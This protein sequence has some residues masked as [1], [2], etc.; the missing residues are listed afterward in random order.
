M[1]LFLVFAFGLVPTF[2]HNFGTI[3]FSRGIAAFFSA[4]FM[5]VAG[6]TF[7]DLFR[8]TARTANAKR[9]Q[10][11]QL[12]FALVMYSVSPFLGPGVGPI[13]GG[14]VVQ[15]LDYRW[16]F[17]I[18]SIWSGLMVILVAVFVPYTYE[19]VLFKRMAARLR[20]STGDARYYAP[21]EEEHQ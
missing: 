17:R 4:S 11:K 18:M 3:L 21:L 7:S 9:D 14:A 6:G 10:H 20:K 1:G 2:A 8:K 12:H 13:I 15:N 16:V 19:P 5:S